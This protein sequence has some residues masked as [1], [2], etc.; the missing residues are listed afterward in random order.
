MNE[1]D[2]RVLRLRYRRLV[3]MIERKLRSG[4]TPTAEEAGFARSMIRCETKL[5]RRGPDLSSQ[6]LLKELMDLLVTQWRTQAPPSADPLQAL[7][8]EHMVWARYFLEQPFTR[9][10]KA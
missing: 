5:L 3:A 7:V 8:G 9:H 10:T 6:A 2:L 1:A 4:Q